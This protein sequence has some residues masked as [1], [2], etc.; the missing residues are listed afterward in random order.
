VN[1][2]KYPTTVAGWVRWL[3]RPYCMRDKDAAL[4]FRQFIMDDKARSLELL[5][6][7]S[8]EAARRRFIVNL[9]CV[10]VLCA[11]LALLVF[12]PW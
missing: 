1:A 8:A 11:F 4:A 12:Q 7:I 3:G 10:T 2:T 6:M 5:N 9:I